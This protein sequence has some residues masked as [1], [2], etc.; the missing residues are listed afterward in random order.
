MKRFLIAGHGQ[1]A[2]GL[3]SSIQVLTGAG[4][5]M[6]IVDA[7]LGDEPVDLGKE[8]DSFIST[9]GTQDT[10][11]VFTDLIGG[12]VNREVLLRTKNHSNIYVISSVN[13]PVILAVILDTEEISRNRLQLLIQ[14]AQVQLVSIENGASGRTDVN[15]F[16]S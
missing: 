8:I 4:N 6:Q 15:D 2:S 7:Y 5:K 14:S 1:L 3:K 12:S 9:V 10:A 16:L 13:L 11:V